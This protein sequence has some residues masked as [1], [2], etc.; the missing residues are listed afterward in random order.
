MD[1]YRIG[2]NDLLFKLSLEKGGGYKEYMH[3]RGGETRVF[4][5]YPGAEANVDLFNV[6]QRN[7]ELSPIDR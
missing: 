1:R 4:T 5:D 6:L 2:T 7:L 3:G